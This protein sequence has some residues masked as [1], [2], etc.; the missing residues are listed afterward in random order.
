[1]FQVTIQV[2]G[3]IVENNITPTWKLSG[4]APEITRCDIGR[5]RK[6]MIAGK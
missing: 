5:D 3:A 2:E 4:Q 6:Q 1:V